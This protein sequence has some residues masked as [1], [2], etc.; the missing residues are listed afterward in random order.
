MDNKSRK[1]VILN[2]TIIKESFKIRL[3]W[4]FKIRWKDL[5]IYKVSFE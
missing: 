2:D 5:K 4:K 1:K 3:I